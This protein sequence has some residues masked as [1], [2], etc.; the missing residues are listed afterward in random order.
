MDL[1][2]DPLEN[3][4]KLIAHERNPFFTSVR[5]LPNVES[6]ETIGEL[7]E[8]WEVQLSVCDSINLIFNKLK[9]EF[10][11]KVRQS[12]NKELLIQKHIAGYRVRKLDRPPTSRKEGYINKGYRWF[13][14]GKTFALKDF[15]LNHK[16][17][18][19]EQ[20]YDET[21]HKSYLLQLDNDTWIYNRPFAE[22]DFLH[23]AEGYAYGKYVH[24]LTC[25]ENQEEG[26]RNVP[27]ESKQKNNS[28]S[29]FWIDPLLG[30]L[31]LAKEAKAKNKNGEWD[32]KIRC[33]AFCEL[34]WDNNYIG[35]KINRIKQCNDFAKSRYFDIEVQLSGSKKTERATHKIRLAYLFK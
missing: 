1:L 15:V 22:R 24:F 19:D 16:E 28:N 17:T 5:V 14:E 25:F 11:H 8:R 21:K 34:L 32:S 35:K 4:L 26:E 23:A 6:R 12:E 27:S 2:S 3:K 9:E 31:F 30:N 33:A 10:I 18:R 13:E 20:V 29:Q 7:M